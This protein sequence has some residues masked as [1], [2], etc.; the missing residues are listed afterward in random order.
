LPTT[1]L[2]E[3]V[4]SL[5][6][7]TEEYPPFSYQ[8]DDRPSG[9]NVELL[10]E[11]LE[12]LEIEAEISIVPWGRAQLFTREQDDSCFFSAARTSDRELIYQWVGPLIEE[13]IV[14]YSLEYEPPA[15]SFTDAAGRAV[16]GQIADAYS[17]WV[18]DQGLVLD[19]VAEVPDNLEKLKRGRIDLWLA[20]NPD[21]PEDW[22]RALNS[23]IEAL[24]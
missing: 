17:D 14:L 11:A 24:R 8:T 18:R 3:P 12:R 19:E 6:L 15:T 7:Y 10:R 13:H 5:R 20:C 2:T 21:I 22:L 9:I 16:G 1:A 23:E 4:N